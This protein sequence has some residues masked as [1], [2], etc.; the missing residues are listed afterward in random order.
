MRRSTEHKG[1]KATVEC[2]V[3]ERNSVH[4]AAD[5]L[6]QQ[7]LKATPTAVHIRL[8]HEKKPRVPDNVVRG[9][10]RWRRRKLG[11]T[12]WKCFE[13]EG[14]FR[15]MAAERQDPDHGELCFAHMDIGPGRFT[16]ICLLV[17]FFAA[18][19]QAHE[20]GGLQPWCYAILACVVMRKL[21]GR[22]RRSCLPLICV[23]SRRETGAVYE[24]ALECLRKECDRRQIPGPSQVCF[25]WF[26]GAATAAERIFPRVRIAQGL[27]HQ[28][29]NILKNQNAGKRV[30]AAEAEGAPRK[31]TKSGKL[32][33]IFHVWQE[34]EWVQYYRSQYMRQVPTQDSEKEGVG[35]FL[36]STWWS[37]LGSRLLPARPA[38]QQ[39]IEAFHAFF[40]RS[41]RSQRVLESHTDV[42]LALEDSVRAWSSP[43]KENEELGS[44]LTS[45]MGPADPDLMSFQR[46]K[47]PDSWM[48]EKGQVLRAPFGKLR[49]YAGIPALVK[50]LKLPNTRPGLSSS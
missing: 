16:W 30:R 27:W 50:R 24:Q 9:I 33:K 28:R 11:F 21:D 49:F 17:P 31:R 26:S 20:Q 18:L 44:K 32:K 48:M 45:L 40:K 12:S 8:A 23:C 34:P 41:L 4:E 35:H 1:K 19:Q 29:R 43:L 36:T 22:W 3:E 42:V 7:G 38:T 47:N 6:I 13:S 14:S 39:P 5:F 37:G 46:P 2:T 10:L 25:D 15:A